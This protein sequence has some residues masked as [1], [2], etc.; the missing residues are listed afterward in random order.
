[1]TKGNKP[2]W[3][4]SKDAYFRRILKTEAGLGA[5]AAERLFRRLQAEIVQVRLR[6]TSPE[7]GLGALH[8]ASVETREI[9]AAAAAPF[10]PYSPNVVVVVRTAGRERALAALSRIDRVEH[11]R[12]LAREQQL[13][14]EAG[15]ESAADIRAAIVSAAE[16][17][18][19]NRRAAA[20]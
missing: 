16:R 5:A 18:I 15:I 8:Q 4:T 12:L 20:S 10:D 2:L 3:G 11:L 7:L 14:I 17:R 1:M 9:D 6:E 13:S 19:A